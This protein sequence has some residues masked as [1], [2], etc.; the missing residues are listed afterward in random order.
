MRQ[1]E[2]KHVDVVVLYRHIT[3]STAVEVE[4]AQHLSLSERHIPQIIPRQGE[5][6]CLTTEVYIVLTL[7]FLGHHR[8]VVG[9]GD[10][11][12]GGLLI[13]TVGIQRAGEIIT[14][15]DNIPFQIVHTQLSSFQ[16]TLV[17]KILIA[18]H[19]RRCSRGCR[20]SRR[21]EITLVITIFAREAAISLLQQKHLVEQH[22]HLLFPLL[23]LTTLFL[24]VCQVV[25]HSID[26]LRLLA[27]AMDAVCISRDSTTDT[28]IFLEIAACRKAILQP[29]VE[30]RLS[31][32]G[33]LLFS[34]LFTILQRIKSIEQDTSYET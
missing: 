14:L 4:V 13:L 31:H 3:P 29:T 27:D 6:G 16:V 32:V 25:K 1:F 10:G 18:H 23:M 28:H 17:T 2:Y 26:G 11:T 24:L 19:Q 5:V 12:D 7:L 22:A 8:Q 30:D 9:S 15:R 20:A 21:V 33:Q 34:R